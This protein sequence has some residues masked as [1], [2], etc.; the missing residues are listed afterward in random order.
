MDTQAPA[1]IKQQPDTSLKN[2]DILDPDY[3]SLALSGNKP[4]VRETVT[5]PHPDPEIYDIGFEGI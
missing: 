3:L 1:D 5:V 4:H 2:G